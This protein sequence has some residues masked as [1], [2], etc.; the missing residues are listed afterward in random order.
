MVAFDKSDKNG[1]VSLLMLALKIL[2]DWYMTCSHKYKK[3]KNSS[4]HILI[5]N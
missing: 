5:N 1:E 2:V 4:S 3:E